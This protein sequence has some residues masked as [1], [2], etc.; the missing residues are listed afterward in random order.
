M[1]HLR[2]PSEGPILFVTLLSL[3]VILLF[4]GGATICMLPLLV[5][6]V[7]AMAYFANA[8]QT[9]ALV[10]QAVPVTPQRAPELSRVVQECVNTLRPG[11]V[12]VFV[13]PTRQLNAYTF[14]LNSPQTV[15]LF[16]PLLKVMDEDELKFIIG[17]ELGHVVLGHTWLNSLIG[18]MAGVPVTLG[19]AVVIIFAFRWWNRA[20]EYS[21]DRA[22][23]VACGDVRKAESALIKLVAG[24]TKNEA[25]L[26]RA[27]EAIDA[28]DDSMVNVLAESLSTHPM[29]IR[30]IQ[31]LRRWAATGEYRKIHG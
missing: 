21:A 27:L 20:C 30:R 15:V 1:S 13:A 5:G 7:V 6:V 8:A 11:S 25:D 9:R 22:G 28:E 23:L 19:A 17:H 16:A 26:A 29:L 10:D 2:Y 31:E 18:G 3:G 24:P 4:G 12:N 14:G